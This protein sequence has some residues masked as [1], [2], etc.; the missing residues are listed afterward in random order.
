MVVLIALFATSLGRRHH[1]S[2]KRRTVLRTRVT[3]L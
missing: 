2:L 1:L 3:G